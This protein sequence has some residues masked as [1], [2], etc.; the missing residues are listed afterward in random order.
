MHAPERPGT[1][2]GHGPRRA[3][4]IGR[5]RS[6]LVTL[7]IPAG[8]SPIRVYRFLFLYPLSGRRQVMGQVRTNDECSTQG[9]GARATSGRISVRQAIDPAVA[10]VFDVE[11]N[12]LGAP[13]RCSPRSA[14]ARQ[15]AMYLAHVVCGLNLTEIGALF[16]R[17]RTT[18]AHACSVV[19]DRRDDPDLDAQIEHLERAVSSLI[20]ALGWRWSC[21]Q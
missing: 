4:S 18:V 20:D 5:P 21:R 6:P 2:W 14:V 8:P 15:V 7:L 12:D 3:P 16:H 19:E 1:G 13:T 11:I 17:D 9:G 10:A